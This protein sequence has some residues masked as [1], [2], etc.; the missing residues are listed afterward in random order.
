M[1]IKNALQQVVKNMQREAIRKN[2]GS[3]QIR[4]IFVILTTDK[5][6]FSLPENR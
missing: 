5:A 6:K 4:K 1:M 2:I 3:L